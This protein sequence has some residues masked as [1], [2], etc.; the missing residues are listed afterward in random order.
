[1]YICYAIELNFKIYTFSSP[2]FYK[3]V[4]IELYLMLINESS[5][6]NIL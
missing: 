3:K 2:S 5:D 4:N 1:M 6:F